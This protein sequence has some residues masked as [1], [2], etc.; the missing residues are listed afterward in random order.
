V[1]A[2]LYR[3]L[4]IADR[5]R[6]EGERQRQQEVER[7]QQAEAERQRQLLTDREQRTYNAAHGNLAALKAYVNSCTVCAYIA[8]A[9]REISQLEN[10]QQ[11]E[12]T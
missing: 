11:E 3:P 7:A 6:V 5:R 1:I 4:V 12:R 9:Q 10:A 8:D 2:R